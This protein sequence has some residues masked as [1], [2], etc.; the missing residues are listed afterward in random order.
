MQ[1]VYKHSKSFVFTGFDLFKW[2]LDLCHDVLETI[3]F[4]GKKQ[5]PQ[6]EEVT[7]QLFYF[8]KIIKN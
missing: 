8:L 6:Y 1:W 2:V 5:P 3:I 4:A 7:N